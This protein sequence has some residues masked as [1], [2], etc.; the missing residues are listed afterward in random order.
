MK[1][2]FETSAK[3]ALHF[4]HK[5]ASSYDSSEV[6]QAKRSELTALQG[7]AAAAGP[8]DPLLPAPALVERFDIES[9]SD[10]SAK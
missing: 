10:F 8:R 3:Q 4:R 7:R 5:L 1:S 2:G 6:L 9:C